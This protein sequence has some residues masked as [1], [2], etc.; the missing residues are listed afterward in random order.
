V[1][2]LYD[3]KHGVRNGQWSELM[4]A[5]VAQLSDEDMVALAAYTASL[6]P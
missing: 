6:A 5:V 1:R 4:K 3:I 2:Q